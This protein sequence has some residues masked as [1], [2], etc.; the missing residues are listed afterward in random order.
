M[1]NLVLHTCSSRGRPSTPP[2][3]S[4]TNSMPACT[5]W[6]SSGNDPAAVFS[7]FTM[8]ST[9]GSPSAFVGSSGTRSPMVE[10]RAHAS[11]SSV[12]SDSPAFAIR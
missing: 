5:A 10:R 7:W 3:S 6:L 9:M 4:F 12:S 2:S 8:P 11:R 1:E